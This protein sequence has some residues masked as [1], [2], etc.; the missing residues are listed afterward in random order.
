MFIVD[1]K[2]HWSASDLA[3]AANCEFAVLRTLDN[4]LGWAAKL[5]VPRDPLEQYVAELGDA[6]END[7]LTQWRA[8]RRVAELPHL[9]PPYTAESLQNAAQA[10]I[11]AFTAQPDV[12]YQP[13]FFDGEFFGYADF[14]EN[15]AEGWLVCDAKLAR[16]AK[17]TAMLQLAAY[18]EQVRAL[19]LPLAPTVSLLLGSGARV[20][21]PVAEITPVFV[22]RRARLRE[23]IGTHLAEGRAVQWGQPG[24]T[25]CGRCP[26][27]EHAANAHNDILVV[28]GMR[29]TQRHRLNEVGITTLA[30]LAT[31]DDAQ[32]PDRMAASTFTNLVAQAGLQWHQ[33]QADSA[34]PAYAMT[35]DAPTV[36]AQLPPPSPGD[37]FFDFE[38][39]PLY[40]ESDR[41]RTGLE[42]LWGVMDAH[43]EFTPL[44]AHD[45]AEERAAFI[46]FIDMLTARRAAY[47]DMHVYHYAAYETT[48]LK[49][50]AM[51]YQ[52]R[53]DALDNLLRGEVFV[54]LYATVRGAVRVATPSYSIKKLEPLYMADDVRADVPDAVAAGA[55]S[56]LAYHDFRHLR[57]SD[58]AAAQARL[59]ALEAYNKYDCLSTLKLRDWLLDR[60]AELGVTSIALAHETAYASADAI[61][62]GPVYDAL[63]ERAEPAPGSSRNPT[64]QAYAMLATALDFHRRDRKQ[65]WWEHYE[66]LHSLE[67]ERWNARDVFIVDS[68]EVVQDW[69]LPMTGRSKKLQRHL[70]LTG[71]W[72][73]G[74]KAADDS[75]VVY[76]RRGHLA[77]EESLPPG[78]RG[79]DS[80]RYGSAQ[81]KSVTKDPHD[82]RVVLLVESR[83][84]G[85]EFDE[86]P[87]ALAPP[88]PP[89]TEVLEDAIA[90]LAS[91]AAFGETEPQLAVWDLLSRRPPR[92]RGGGA[93]PQPV[94]PD[95]TIDT[96]VAALLAMDSSYL[97]VQGPPGTGKTYTGAHVIKRLVEEHGWRIGV[98]SQSHAAVET[99]LDAI[100]DAGLNTAV[101]G[102]SK[103]RRK[104]SLWTAVTNSS[105]ARARF[106][107]KNADGG[108]VLGGTAWTFA[109]DKGVGREQLDLLVIDEAGQFS[110]AQTLAASVGAKRL[111]LLGDPQQLPQ[112]TQ[113]THAEPVDDSALGWLMRD[114]A[115]VPPEFGYFLGESYRMHPQL[116]QAVSALSYDGRLTSAPLA[117]QR[118]LEGIAPGL[119]FSVI[120]HIGNSTESAE[121]AHEVV[122]LVSEALGRPWR[123]SS[124]KAARP[125]E[126]SDFIVVAPYNAQVQ[127]IRKTL[128]AAG[129]Q[130]VPVGT[131]DNFQGKEA[132]IAIVSMTASSHDEIP[133]GMDFLLNRN[134]VNVA[135][136]RAQWCAVVVRSE[137]LS[138]FM[139]STADGVLELGAFL[140]LQ[141]PSSPEVGAS[142][143]R[144]DYA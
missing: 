55:D 142:A 29:M 46:T 139:P 22:E 42:Y 23:L 33:L 5:D 73:P 112:V 65:F 56:V 90:E 34:V 101:V 133:R 54:D 4:K 58:P 116:C 118:H 63:M 121:E 120:D 7:I 144:K 93:L 67:S 59:D 13:A 43:G 137:A 102:K 84:A 21:F 9:P 110:L 134:R 109:N 81:A 128:N 129:L 71:Q 130:E 18:A 28:A 99:M 44:W 124:T 117:G 14:V 10:S 82:E 64:Q 97:A 95:G 6:Y 125:L 39:D 1:S 62:G 15:T 136:S 48:A 60:A 3:T 66:R 141:A 119:R 122:R 61:E 111:M 72:T 49:H 86:L 92:L 94:T 140:R 78:V 131:V 27:C 74:S 104:D 108:C 41:S 113:G 115:T 68:A 11:A 98:V 47:P 53:E 76:E 19:E 80:S 106:L 20:D 32:R 123:G 30:E 57:H 127:A 50:L 69:A 26:E 24:V 8:E 2:V 36:L 45:R 17:P 31:A 103:P 105:Q 52:T 38:G 12:V 107:D 35:P 16:H 40:F 83:D 132:V 114:H 25:A 85:D 70:R 126:Q 135:V 89:D 37:L 96:V 88:F 87:V 100:V 143:S 51:R 79:T 75:Q 77:G 91:A 138:A